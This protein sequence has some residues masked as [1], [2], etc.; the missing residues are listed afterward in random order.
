MFR[1]ALPLLCTGILA[2][3]AAPAQDPAPTFHE[4]MTSTNPN[5]RDSSVYFTFLNGVGER[6]PGV[7]LQA[8]YLFPPSETGAVDTGCPWP[9]G[10]PVAPPYWF[11]G[12]GSSAEP[13]PNGTDVD[14][15]RWP[16]HGN[17]SNRQKDAFMGLIFTGFFAGTVTSAPSGNALVETVFYHSQKCYFAST[18]FGFFRDMIAQQTY[19]YYAHDANCG[20]DL[21]CRSG[22]EASD[23]YVNST[24]A[25]IA[26]PDA[27]VAPI[28]YMAWL[29]TYQSSGS[30]H[31]RFHVRVV[32]A[33]KAVLFDSVEAS[34]HDALLKTMM[35]AS[36]YVTVGIV[37]VDVNGETMEDGVQLNASMV[38][39]FEC[40]TGP[41]GY[42]T[43]R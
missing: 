29:D 30:T 26:I 12:P 2:L 39:Y 11:T 20:V 3:S 33:T 37:R 28:T 1:T 13:L 23:P 14:V 25:N 32:D 22:N 35:A 8:S 42:C 36:G 16:S 7:T 34:G 5:S 31:Y 19:F 15:S 6:N 10:P 17:V 38:G 4:L 24:G 18:E 40:S 41:A 27:G 21:Y 43:T 9:V